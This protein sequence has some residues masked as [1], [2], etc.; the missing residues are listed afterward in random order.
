MK[1]VKNQ[2]RVSILALIVLSVGM[3]FLT[4]C[5]E[6]DPKVDAM[7][8]K[9]AFVSAILNQ[10]LMYN[11]EPLADSGTVVTE[12]VAYGMFSE[13]SPCLNQLNSAIELR[14]SN[15]IYFICIGETNELKAGTWD[16][17]EERTILTLSLSA[18][19]MAGPLQLTITNLVEGT[20]TFSGSASNLPIPRDLFGL[21]A[22]PLDPLFISIDLVFTKL[23]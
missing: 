11:M 9:Y 19:P 18:P 23:P 12:I 20:L 16:I 4:S 14:K 5:V 1:K 7:V 13:T 22:D 15:E 21:E 3:V 17:N 8:G 2:I 6:D 10:D